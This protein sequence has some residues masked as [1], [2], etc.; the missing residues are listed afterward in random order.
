MHVVG[1]SFPG[2]SL[3]IGGGLLVQ[4]RPFLGCRARQHLRATGE[5][6]G[7]L[8][9]E[10]LSPVWGDHLVD[11]GCQPALVK[12]HAND[13]RQ[14]Q[15]GQH[16]GRAPPRG[17]SRRLSDGHPHCLAQQVGGSR[18]RMHADDVPGRSAEDGCQ[19]DVG[20]A[21]HVDAPGEVALDDEPAGAR[22]HGGQ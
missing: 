8:V 5:M 12:H 11:A 7:E 20:R 15:G 13:G 22:S 4:E 14:F 3:G 1:A 19:P 9:E 10:V 16:D 2:G 17:A 18:R 6:G 21:G